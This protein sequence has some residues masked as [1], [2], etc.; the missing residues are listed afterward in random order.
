MTKPVTRTSLTNDLRAL[1][2]EPGAVVLVHSSLSGLG[3][4]EGGA[5]AVVD[6]LLDAVGERGTILFPT[7]TG[8]ER[9]G[10]EY[11]PHMDVRS[12]PC[13]TGAIPEAARKRPDAV[14][15]LHP[16]HS[17]VA[18]GTETRQFTKGHE[19]VDTPCGPGS[20][21]TRLMDAGGSILLLGGVTHASNTSLHAIE[22]LAGVPYHLQPE[23]TDGVVIDSSGKRFLV[24]NRLH[25]W[26]W[27]R[28]FPKV[29]VVL[30]SHGAGRSGRVGASMSTLVPAARLRA[31]LL[32]VLRDD[33]L[34]LLSNDAREAFRTSAAD[35]AHRRTE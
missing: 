9:D 16:T 14:R 25:L 12:T 26:Q 5:D 33:P 17:V 30:E 27:E 22:E 18:L 34:Y 10:P 8:S 11:P 23:A 31:L 4:V 1:G 28:N 20:P 21:Y 6:A 7:L 15:S 19:H 35:D 32:P 24:R 29:K 3:W 2:I 13:W